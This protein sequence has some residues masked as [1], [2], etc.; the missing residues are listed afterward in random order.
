MSLLTIW[1]EDLNKEKH[2]LI[3]NEH[4]WHFTPLLSRSRPSIRDLWS[5]HRHNAILLQYP[6]NYSQPVVN[7]KRNSFGGGERS[8]GMRVLV[9]D[10]AVR[11]AGIVG[12]TKPHSE[13]LRHIAGSPR[14]IMQDES[15]NL[16]AAAKIGS[17]KCWSQSGGITLWT[18]GMHCFIV[19]FP[20]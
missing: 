12:T 8:R 5:H 4:L 17:G 9:V 15:A 18:T 7:Y 6:T 16:E 20:K 10:L 3:D 11:L 13:A 14:S 1:W 19:P 2:Q